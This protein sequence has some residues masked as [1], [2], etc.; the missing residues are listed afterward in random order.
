M[1]MHY[2]WYEILK[3]LYFLHKIQISLDW[4]H[5]S[6]SQFVF[7]PDCNLI[8]FGHHKHCSRI[9]SHITQIIVRLIPLRIST[10]CIHLCLRITFRQ[11]LLH[12]FLNFD[13]TN[14][15]SI[16]CL[17]NTFVNRNVETDVCC[18]FWNIFRLKTL[19]EC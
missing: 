9:C 2:S 12:L 10:I 6:A 11:H 1:D 7:P 16:R 15:L 14:H 4:Q 5:M 3:I 19:T 18:K 8:S 13:I 17:L